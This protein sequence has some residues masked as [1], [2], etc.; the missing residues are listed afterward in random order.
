MNLILCN[1]KSRLFQYII[2]YTF[3]SESREIFPSTLGEYRYIIGRKIMTSE[4]TPVH[5]FIRRYVFVQRYGDEVQRLSV[6]SMFT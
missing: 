3:T 2:L 5:V 4:R 6:G 1:D